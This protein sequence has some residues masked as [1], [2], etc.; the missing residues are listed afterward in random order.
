MSVDV[1]KKASGRVL[2]RMISAGV[3]GANGTTGTE[4][5]KLLW[6]HPNVDIAYLSSRSEA[7]NRLSDIDPSAPDIRLVNV[8][9]EDP[10]LL[11]SVRGIFGG[12]IDPAAVDVVFSCLPHGASAATVD[13]LLD[14]GLTV[15]DLSGD[16]RLA[17]ATLHDHVYGSV[18]NALHA[19]SRVYGLTEWAYAGLSTAS[20][21]ANPGC[22]PTSVLMPLLPI[23]SRHDGANA[24]TSPVGLAGGGD[25]ASYTD[26]LT[27][28][29]INSVSGVSGA[30]RRASE[31]THFCAAYGDV[32]PYLSC[33]AHRHLAEMEASLR[34]YCGLSTLPHIVFNPHLV[35]LERGMLSTLTLTFEG[36][37]PG[38]DGSL[39]DWVHQQLAAAYADAYFVRV[40][41]LGEGEAR[42]RAAS[43]N[44]RVE[45]SVHAEDRFSVHGA[46]DSA[47]APRTSV[48][49][50]CAIDN[51]LKGAAGQAVQNM[52]IMFGFSEEEGLSL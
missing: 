52:N 15:I 32:R 23:L 10:S 1:E 49:I 16:F 27:S 14:R 20:L 45:I 36:V 7:G 40:L 11:P 37:R 12:E 34:E 4:L 8:L 22:Y 33:R 43:G 21:V 41:P 19:S 9:T 3:L 51:L 17:D 38:D 39:G 31:R 50:C 25:S 5:A 28:I 24:S 42:I 48:V 44:N 26:R 46:S 30:G 13:M 29:V 47:A 6:H 2:G 35:P 18:R